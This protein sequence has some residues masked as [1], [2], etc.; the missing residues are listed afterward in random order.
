MSERRQHVRRDGGGR[1]IRSINDRAAVDVSQPEYFSC[2]GRRHRLYKRDKS[3][4]K[5]DAIYRTVTLQ[6][7]SRSAVDKYFFYPA[8]DNFR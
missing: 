6:G 7:T 8:V 4:E 2:F 1:W 3:M 5:R